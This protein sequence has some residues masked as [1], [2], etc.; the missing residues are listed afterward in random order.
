MK[1]KKFKIPLIALILVAILITWLAW[2]KSKAVEAAQV[3]REPI[4]QSIVATGKI[5]TPAR[6]EIAA[7]VTGTVQKVLVR[8]GD[9]VKQGQL[10]LALKSDE[11]Q[12]ALL[13]TKAALAEAQ[14]HLQQIDTVTALTSDQA[15]VQA[16]ANLVV[17]QKDFQRTQQLVQEGFFSASRLDEA[18]RVLANTQAALT[19]ARAQASANHKDGADRQLAV[20]RV[21]QAQ[22]NVVAAK[23]RLDNLHITAP[24]TS[25]V[26]TRDVEA[27]D[28]A[29][30]G[31][32]LLSLAQA[33]ETRISAQVDEK[34]LSNLKIGFKG[35][36]SADAFPTQKFPVE[37][38]YIAPAVDAQR[39]A[40]EIR[41]HVMDPPSFLRA[42][43][44]VSVELIVGK[45][46]SALVAPSDTI[47]DM[48]SA[49]PY[50]LVIRNGKADR[51]TVALGLRGVG[52][53]E[54]MTGVNE[55]EWLIS[56][57]ATAV[58]GDRVNPKSKSKNI[59]I[60]SVPAG[61]TGR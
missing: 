44:T 7:P 54:I 39:G 16:E 57:T 18:Q 30:A 42:D 46:N 36:A 32:V 58:E 27:G 11:A 6:I 53:S 26:M 15:V 33:G 56:Q 51:Q 47:R 13:Q 19:A 22:A 3:V 48:Q 8:E 2:P 40:V 14:A 28:V 29:Q 50:V 12:A 34:N 61:L 20:A 10:L 23:A 37:L 25:V 38:N 59:G 4:V 49:Q 24:N 1:F 21:A 41:L 5:E 9:N 43:M 55:G 35:L 45:K 17:A 60:Q 52:Q 31:K